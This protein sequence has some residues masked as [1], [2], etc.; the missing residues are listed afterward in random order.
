MFTLNEVI[1]GMKHC[2]QNQCEGCPGAKDLE[3]FECAEQVNHTEPL[4]YLL[5][6]RDLLQYM[7]TPAIP[8][9]IGKRW[10][11]GECSTAIGKYW[12][13]CQKCG[14]LIDWDHAETM[15]EI[16]G[17]GDLLYCGN[18]G[19]DIYYGLENCLECGKK[20]NWD[21]LGIRIQESG[22]RR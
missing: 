1:D 22:S 13:Y 20:L 9:K 15:A 10:H 14:H 19:S 8:Y 3:G 12:S 16:C 7:K 11:C 2:R 17:S 6:Y 4:R 5:Q 21:E 18:C